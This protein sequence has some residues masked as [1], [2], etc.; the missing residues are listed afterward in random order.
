LRLH[1]VV[2]G[3]EAADE[4]VFLTLLGINGFSKP[5]IVNAAAVVESPLDVFAV[6]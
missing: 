5:I 6:E 4:C 1:W 3:I 2:A